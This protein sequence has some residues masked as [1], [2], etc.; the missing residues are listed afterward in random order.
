MVTTG[1]DFVKRLGVESVPVED[2]Q[3][4]PVNLTPFGAPVPEQQV[5][6]APYEPVVNPD[7]R[8]DARVAKAITGTLGERMG[9]V[10]ARDEGFFKEGVKGIQRGAIE[11]TGSV[12][13]TFGAD[14]LKNWSDDFLAINQQLYDSDRKGTWSYTSNLIGAQISGNLPLLGATI[15]AGVL[16]GGTGAAVVAGAGRA[17]KVASAVRGLTALAAKQAGKAASKKFVT[18]II[19][20]KVLSAQLAGGGMVGMMMW[21]DNL[22]EIRAKCPDLSEGGAIA[23]NVFL[24]PLHAWIEMMMG[25][26]KSVATG[27]GKAAVGHAMAREGGLTA[28]K[29]ATKSVATG[30]IARFRNSFTGQWLGVSASES[31]EEG[32]QK[33]STDVTTSLFGKK[34]NTLTNEEQ[35]NNLLSEYW[36]AMKEGFIGG[37][38]LGVLP[39]TL[40][41]Y[42][43]NEQR[44]KMDGLTRRDEVAENNFHNKVAPNGQVFVDSEEMQQ[45]NL[46]FNQFIG[47]F[48]FEVASDPEKRTQ[49]IE[50]IRT[51]CY[52][53]AA[54]ERR[55][56]TDPAKKAAIL[57][58]KYIKTLSTLVI[59]DPAIARQLFDTLSEPDISTSEAIDAV[60]KVQSDFGQIVTDMGDV[61]QTFEL[62]KTNKRTVWEV[63]DRLGFDT[64]T[65]M[66]D[67]RKG[68]SDVAGDIA[69]VVMGGAALPRGE[70]LARAKPG[71]RV[72]PNAIERVMARLGDE[73]SMVMYT[74]GWIENIKV[75]GKTWAIKLVPDV[76][77]SGKVAGIVF[78]QEDASKITK[79][80][81]DALDVSEFKK[82]KGGAKNALAQST[83]RQLAL[84]NIVE[85]LDSYT[86]LS[87]N[88]TQTRVD[89]MLGI[90]KVVGEEQAEVE[91]IQKINDDAAVDLNE[92][93]VRLGEKGLT[94]EQKTKIAEGYYEKTTAGLLTIEGWYELPAAEQ[95]EVATVSREMGEILT[96]ISKQPQPSAAWAVLQEKAKKKTKVKK[97][98]PE[99]EPVVDE[100][101]GTNAIYLVPAELIIVGTEGDAASIMHELVHHIIENS[102]MPTDIE[103]ILRNNFIS[104]DNKTR[105]FTT[106]EKENVSNAFL[107]YVLIGKVPRNPAGAKAFGYLKSI[108]GSTRFSKEVGGIPLARD[109]KGAR[110]GYVQGTTAIKLNDET[111]KMFE[112]LLSV[113][114]ADSAVEIYG[115]A[116]DTSLDLAWGGGA[117]VLD[118]VAIKDKIKELSAL[119][120]TSP[121][122]V[123]RAM[124]EKYPE[125]LGSTGD[126]SRMTRMQISNLD[127]ILENELNAAVPA[128]SEQA[129]ELPSLL[130][131][132]RAARVPLLATEAKRGL[133]FTPEERATA[134]GTSRAGGAIGAKALVPKQVSGEIARGDTVLNYGSGRVNKEGRIP[135]SD[136]VEEA[137]G[138]VI[139]YDFPE[140]IREGV[141]DPIALGRQYDVVMA[142]NVLNVQSSEN[143]LR[144]TISE[145]NKTVKK[146]GK[147]IVNYPLAPR[148]SD[149]STDHLQ[150]VLRE[151][152]SGVEVVGGTKNAPVFRLTKPTA[153]PTTDL[154]VL[155]EKAFKRFETIQAM[156]ENNAEAKEAKNKA[157]NSYI[158]GSLYRGE[159]PLGIKDARE[160]FGDVGTIKN[161]T[162]DQKITLAQYRIDKQRASSVTEDDELSQEASET[163]VGLVDSLTPGN[164]PDLAWRTNDGMWT[165]IRKSS[166][167]LVHRI[168]EKMHDLRSMVEWISN[169]API[170][171]TNFSKPLSRIWN[172]RSF[173]STEFRKNFNKDAKARGIDF[174]VV[175]DRIDFGG[176]RFRMSDSLDI[177]LLTDYGNDPS[178][179]ATQKLLESN[180]EFT[181]DIVDSMIKFVKGDENLSKL[182]NLMQ[183]YNDK[184]F[185]SAADV[186]EEITGRR[187]EKI[188]TAYT[189]GEYDGD[190]LV[191]FDPE[192]EFINFKFMARD[193]VRDTPQ[194]F[195][196]RTKEVGS[197]YNTDSFGKFFRHID[198]LINYQTKAREVARMLSLLETGEMRSGF[199]GKYGDDAYRAAMIKMIWRE[200]SPSGHLR[201]NTIG[202]RG[203]SD[204]IRN[205]HHAFLGYNM[206]TIL[207]Q[208][209][210]TGP[211]LAVLGVKAIPRYF[212]NV[213]KIT[214]EALSRFSITAT[215]AYKFV[216][217]KSPYVVGDLMPVKAVDEFNNLIEEAGIE[218]LR[219]KSK[220]FINFQRKGM[221]PMS[222]TDMVIRMAT[223]ITAY[224]T[225]FEE[226]MDTGRT[227]SEMDNDARVWA[228][229]VIR[230]SQNPSSRGELGLL[231]TESHAT[232]RSLLAFTSQP[233]ANMKM[234]LNDSLL[235]V[236]NAAQK[237]GLMGAGKELLS[238][239][240]LYRKILFGAML[241]GIAL[242]AIG[243][244]RR[245]ENMSEL[246]QDAIVMGIGNL[247]PVIGNIIWFRAITGFEGK[248]SFAGIHGQLIKS[249]TDVISNVT[250]LEVDF[251]TIRSSMTALELLTGIP[252]WPLK[253]TRELY[254][255]IY[256]E[257]GKFD[258][259]SLF[260]A[261]FGKPK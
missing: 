141:H 43:N 66:S 82:E 178:G 164:S 74:M 223:Y 117:Q 160:M 210:A 78:K 48:G 70:S 75:G 213:S 47:S 197:K 54:M 247:I 124:I 111:I 235:P 214:A 33:G 59:K 243:R 255:D 132:T 77:E 196:H 5:K 232:I 222:T 97:E 130:D 8:V 40:N 137:G 138:L 150:G 186:R 15:A 69:R 63:K 76:N 154:A 55:A 182:G 134:T 218:G 181:Q 174:T 121:E 136:I 242:G 83:L 84:G 125:A 44:R 52:N 189:R 109:A 22:D 114:I 38:A 248:A 229:D 254:K 183:E 87:D 57:P 256:I 67:I 85:K 16:T 91:R 152:F 227:E 21:G 195:K 42:V 251:T 142:S 94:D 89:E 215:D 119:M 73:A 131:K 3:Q 45:T 176:V 212:A 188:K 27:V 17:S 92:L 148:K 86:E 198:T 167:K 211:S 96:G 24:T 7:G 169:N 231:Q 162:I 41:A 122:G 177:W 184:Y 2:D 203:V 151:Y 208:A 239:G 250:N 145:I 46:M 204:L 228:E 146:D 30:K 244:R 10:E 56:E 49:A 190:S 158:N 58:E 163:I 18:D 202:E 140:N 13:N 171:V 224:Q 112:S 128:R 161:L 23:V 105:P 216:N 155:Q 104:G 50:N 153:K 207:T 26:N 123:T 79:A 170:W 100:I 221:L 4:K 240:S 200:M 113:P 64:A 9:W 129:K 168:L 115:N 81:D 37:M 68:I 192:T 257:K 19:A 51:L 234:F 133:I 217:E 106:A 126:M 12:A 135:H 236:L 194:E 90:E 191:S 98:V 185:D 28:I 209:T 31:F 32:L 193:G 143:M 14:R 36:Q 246:L 245:Q 103:N 166:T 20:R 226:L 95:P 147:A 241:P 253:V 61:E 258:G 201:R 1:Q 6:A 34:Q 175:N 101:E 187:P 159:K 39:V 11:L 139:N 259:Q 120:K 71:M 220:G 149:V 180:K 25:V 62:E 219:W 35:W 237:S 157:L 249:M 144:R 261:A 127:R 108:V 80:T 173:S 118:E 116:L 88:L 110:G 172:N 179:I 206:N 156:P 102:L 99:G 93:K 225:K 260:E 233:F 53:L 238:N 205:A 252:D 29:Q 199:I 107:Q 65:T 60:N 230:K 72:S 165:K